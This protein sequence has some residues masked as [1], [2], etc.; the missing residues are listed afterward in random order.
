MRLKWSNIPI[1]EAHIIGLI[2][3]IILNSLYPHGVN[4]SP[5]LRQLIGWPAIALGIFVA[6]WAVITVA[7]MD[8]AAPTGIITTGPYAFSRNPMYVGWT[9][10]SLGISLI[11]NNIWILFF[12][13]LAVL[14]NHK[15]VV[16]K[17]EHYMEEHFGDQYRKYRN[18]VRRYL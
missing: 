7:D 16:L 6:G 3:G 10:I 1:P 2:T 17:E 8:V 13:V 12:L 4:I 9:F 18:E 5:I 14:Y 11:T 15:Y